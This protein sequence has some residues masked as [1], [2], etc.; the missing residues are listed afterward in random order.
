MDITNEPIYTETDAQKVDAVLYQAMFDETI[1]LRKSISSKERR[2][3]RAFLMEA[4]QLYYER[5]PNSKSELFRLVNKVY[6]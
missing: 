5:N 2:E 4:Y 3:I 6:H 1:R